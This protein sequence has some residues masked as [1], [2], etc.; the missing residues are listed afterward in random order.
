[1]G[2]YSALVRPVAFLADAETMHN[3]AIR[4]AEIAGRSALACRAVAAM[5]VRDYERLHC[6]VAGLEF[7]NPLGLAAGYDK[8]GR[9]ARFWGSLGFGHVEIGPVSADPSPGN[10]RPR[11][12]RIPEDRGLIVNYGLPNEGADRV[13]ARLSC[14]AASVPVGV[15]IVNTNRGPGACAITPDAMI[16]DYIRSIRRLEAHAAYLMLNLSC[17]NTADGRD[18]VSGPGQV[19]RLLEAVTEAAPRKPVFLKVA[20]FASLQALE[21]FLDQVDAFPVVRGFGVN[22]PPGKPVPLRLRQSRL[23]SMPGAV[24]GAPCRDIMD[25]A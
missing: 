16:E 17:P 4:A 15:N 18:F 24:S 25:R 12:W 22:L 9:A 21:S 14:R 7:R 13:A 8:N 19:R 5:Y 10:P 23:K 6:S 3:V 20:P 11:L 1:M 2:I